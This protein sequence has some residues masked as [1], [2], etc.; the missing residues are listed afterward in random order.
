[1]VI[2]C[3]KCNRHVNTGTAAPGDVV[4][5][6]CGLALMVPEGPAAAG[7]MNCPACG[8]PVDPDL[9]RCNYCD[10]KL[11][12]VICPRCFGAVFEGVRHCPHC[13]EA[14]SERMVIHHGDETEHRCPRCNEVLRVEVVAGTPLERCPACEGLWVDRETAERLYKDREQADPVRKMTRPQGPPRQEVDTRRVKKEGYIKCPVCRNIMN[15]QNFGRFSGVIIDIC[16]KHGTWFDA[17]ELR[18]IL[19]FIAAGGLD[20]AARREKERLEQEIRH[21]KTQRLLSGDH[22]TGAFGGASAF[23]GRLASE[24]SALGL[25]GTLLRTILK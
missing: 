4:Q 17:D 25:V 20:K 5:C 6:R 16:M 1:V 11:A 21:L 2:T 22:E 12:T 13:G 8:A 19:D 7:K 18:R 15:R 23:S 14:L 9:A 24:R 10:T 3:L